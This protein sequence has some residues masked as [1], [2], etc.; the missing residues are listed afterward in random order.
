MNL[1][2]NLPVTASAGSSTRADRAGQDDP[3]AM[4]F[5]DMLEKKPGKGVPGTADEH[6]DSRRTTWSWTRIDLAKNR[7]EWSAGTEAEAVD[8]SRGKDADED[9]I[10]ASPEVTDGGSTE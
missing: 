10:D 9:S 3:A 2:A 4:K 1:P 6:A 5:D 8:P 7:M